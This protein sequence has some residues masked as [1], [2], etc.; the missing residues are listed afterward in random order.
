MTMTCGGDEWLG[1]GNIAPAILTDDP[2]QGNVRVFPAETGEKAHEITRVDLAVFMVT[3][4]AIDEHRYQAV[5]STN[6]GETS[7]VTISNNYPELSTSSSSCLVFS[8]DLVADC[9]ASTPNV[10]IT[11]LRPYCGACSR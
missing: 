2:A 8:L 9:I 3:R 10:T 5:T 4:L 6:S 11:S 1:L 7:A